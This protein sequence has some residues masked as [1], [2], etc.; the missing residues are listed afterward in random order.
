MSG[1]RA[2][3]WSS[4]AGGSN[5][6][7]PLFSAAEPFRFAFDP[8]I[9]PYRV[10]EMVTSTQCR[11]PFNT[12]FSDHQFPCSTSPCSTLP[13]PPLRPLQPCPSW[14]IESTSAREGRATVCLV[15]VEVLG[16]GTCLA[17][18][19]FGKWIPMVFWI[20]PA[21]IRPVWTVEDV[22]PPVLSC[23]LK[24]VVTP[25]GGKAGRL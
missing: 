5:A 24:P 14:L 2:V 10:L 19:I 23:S 3:S 7:P 13:F 18:W 6:I 11:T 15:H 8:R 9:V 25:L 21:W 4:A 12:P 16:L 22:A 17:S 1:L 20:C